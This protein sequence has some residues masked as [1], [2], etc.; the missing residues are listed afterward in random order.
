MS[1]VQHSISTSVYTTACS[2][3]KVVSLCHHAVE[4]LYP[5]HPPPTS[6]LVTTHLFSMSNIIHFLNGSSKS[7]CAFSIPLIGLG[8][9]F[10]KK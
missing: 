8:L 9:T 1:C 4:P 6:P 10:T 2:P 5:F 3:P 7:I